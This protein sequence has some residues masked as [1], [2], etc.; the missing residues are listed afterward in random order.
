MDAL[1]ATD[2]ASWDD[3]GDAGKTQ[4]ELVLIIGE[5]HAYLYEY[6]HSPRSH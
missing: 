1:K 6:K 2:R 3:E 4:C 5:I